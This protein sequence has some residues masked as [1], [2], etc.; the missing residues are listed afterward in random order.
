M[1]FANLETVAVMKERVA[2]STRKGYDSIRIPFMIWL[3]DNNHR[4][5]IKPAILKEMERVDKDDKSRRTQKGRKCKKKDYLRERC[6]DILKAIN[7]IQSHT[8]P[9][10]LEELTI[11]V[12]TVY[13]KTF[14]K[15]VKR[16]SNKAF[17][18][19][20]VEIR[21]K[22]TSFDGACSSLS[23][24][25]QESGVDKYVNEVT[26]GLWSNITIYKKG[27]RNISAREHHELGLSALE[28]K[29]PL[30]FRAFWYLARVLFESED[31]TY[32]VAHT[33]LLLKWNFIS[34]AEF[35]VGAKV[36]LV[37]ACEDA[38]VF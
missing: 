26:K 6:G 20:E 4:N 15:K 9:I 34:Q 7:L 14:K 3:F 16:G 23:H 5:I 31:P 10:K 11:Q 24:L 33:F 13:W 21:L 12:F 17:G 37:S 1:Y 32:I 29:K 25:F 27:T 35:V 19:E 18:N 22:P 38:L 36:D 8:L 2:Q 30:P 28:E